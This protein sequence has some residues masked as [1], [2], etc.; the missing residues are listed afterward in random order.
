MRKSRE[1]VISITLS[2]NLNFISRK[3]FQK[4]LARQGLKFMLNTKVVSADK[5]DGKVFIKTE[6]AKGGKEDS[7]RLFRSSDDN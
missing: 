5:K 7:V 3:T 4:T 1:F 6:S 2:N